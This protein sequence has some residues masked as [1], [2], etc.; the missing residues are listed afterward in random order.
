MT[1]NLEKIVLA[2]TTVNA[3]VVRLAVLVEI[4][5]N[6]L[7]DRALPVALVG[8]YANVANKKQQAV[9]VVMNVRVLRLDRV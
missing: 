3:A 9:P 5:V 4:N 8:M 7:L 1:V 6:V 2:V